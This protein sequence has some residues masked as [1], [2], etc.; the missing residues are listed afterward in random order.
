MTKIGLDD[1][2]MKWSDESEVP[3]SQRVVAMDDR[4]KNQARAIC[5]GSH[6]RLIERRGSEVKMLV[7]LAHEDF[8]GVCLVHL[9]DADSRACGSD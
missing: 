1:E 2:S 9:K 3:A 7:V 5:A 4:G 6:R 8:D